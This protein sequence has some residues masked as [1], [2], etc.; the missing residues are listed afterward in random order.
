MV[1][2]PRQPCLQAD[3]H[4][5]CQGGAQVDYY[6]VSGG[7]VWP[8]GFQYL[9]AAIIGKTSHNLNASVTIWRFFAGYHR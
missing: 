1:A 2:R 3:S 6:D 5:G 7:H 9:P 8:D 4:G